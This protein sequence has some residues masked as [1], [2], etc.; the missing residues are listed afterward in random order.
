MKKRQKFTK[1]D[2]F[3]ITALYNFYDF[4]A[5]ELAED[6][7]TTRQHIHKIIRRTEKIFG[8]EIFKNKKEI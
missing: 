4:R 7:E 1:T 6:F 3:C 8:K 5:E 2:W